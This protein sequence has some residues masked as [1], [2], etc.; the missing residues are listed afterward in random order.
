MATWWLAAGID[1]AG[2]LMWKPADQAGGRGW[3]SAASAPADRDRRALQRAIV[4]PRA[5]DDVGDQVD[6]PA[7][8]SPRR[9]SALNSAGKSRLATCGSAR[10]CS[11]RHESRRTIFVGKVGKTIHLLGGGIARRSPTGFSD[12]TTI[13]SPAPC[14]EY[15]VLRQRLDSGSF[16]RPLQLVRMCGSLS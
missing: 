5:G 12:S 16:A 4:E 6:V 15:R 7:V 11:W 14:A 2:E 13:E 8:A 10:F 1:A 9:S 3:R